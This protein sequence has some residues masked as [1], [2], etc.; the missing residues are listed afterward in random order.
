MEKLSD[1][2]KELSGLDKAELILLCI[3]MAKLKKEN[4]E[5]LSFL[6]SDSDDPQ[7][8]AEKLKPELDAVWQEPFRSVWALNK[9][10]RKS[11]RLISKYRRFTAHLRGE[12]ELMIYFQ[13][14]FF[15]HWKHGFN[16]RRFESMSDQNLRKIHK[17]LSQIDEEFRADYQPQIDDLE[18]T[19]NKRF[20]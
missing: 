5:F 20:I 16:N 10:L 1:I 6:I 13:Q 19:F 15:E 2:K 4:K 14:G 11:L 17:L 7:Y 18:K 12:L 3:R 8:Y 9:S